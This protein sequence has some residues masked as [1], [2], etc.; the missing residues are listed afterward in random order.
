[1]YWPFMQVNVFNEIFW[2]TRCGW[3]DGNNT[4]SFSVPEL[5]SDAVVHANGLHGLL[6][7][8]LGHLPLLLPAERRWHCCRGSGLCA[9]PPKDP[10]GNARG[11][12]GTEK[13]VKE[14]GKL[15]KA[16]GRFTYRVGGCAIISGINF[17]RN[18]KGPTAAMDTN[19]RFQRG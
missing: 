6:R 2:H 14:K 7:L 4:E 8:P 10:G 18:C 19:Q 15:R 12:F 5:C 1:M 9:G 16:G 17:F 3:N 13:N 11:S